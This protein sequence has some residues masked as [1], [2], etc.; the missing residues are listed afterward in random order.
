MLENPVEFAERLRLWSL[1]EGLNLLKIALVTLL[2]W[3][4]FR[5]FVKKA[6][7]WAQDPHDPQRER[8]IKTMAG[9]LHGF[10]SIVLIAF[11]FATALREF[12]LDVRPLLAGAGVAGVAIGFGA[13]NIVRDVL[14]GAFILFDN[15]YGIGDTIRTGNVTGA[16]EQ[17][18]LRRT[19]VRDGSG[20]LYTVPNGEIRIVANL[21]RSWA[22]V[23]FSIPVA[24]TESLDRVLE[25]LRATAKDLQAIPELQGCILEPP[26]ILGIDKLSG[27]QAE[28]MVTV[29]TTPGKQDDVSRAW[30]RLIKQA[31]ERE[32]IS[33][34]DSTMVMQMNNP[35]DGPNQQSPAPA[36]PA[37]ASVPPRAA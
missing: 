5:W 12:G 2:L 14:S 19:V 7:E 27:Q 9:V 32:G 21:S 34:Q 10:G 29:K 15:Q 20:A 18:T 17:M 6:P 3:E 25:M 26:A 28:I 36:T 1:N 37:S 35:P 13:Q 33:F 31:F 23:A 4:A 22:Q 24:I 11:A 16:V 8:Q 30:R